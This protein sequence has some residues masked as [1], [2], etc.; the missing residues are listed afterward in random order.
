M[1]K[2]PID[3]NKWNRKEH[4]EF[5]KTFEDPSF[6][7][8]FAVD[9][10]VAYAKAKDYKY[11]FFAMY[12]HACTKALNTVENFRYRIEDDNVFDYSPIHAS[13]TILRPDH[14]FGFSFIDYSE[15]IEKFHDNY[16]AEKDRIFSS[17]SLFPPKNGLDCFHCSALPWINFTG[18]KEPFRA[19]G[20]S[21]PQIAFSKIKKRQKKMIMNISIS[22]NH[23]LVDG[24]HVGQF[25]EKFQYYLNE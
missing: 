10:S 4:F 19:P 2:K 5:F 20:N 17:P 15:D 6:A 11:S 24:Y 22:V 16:L 13:A 25:A 7:V 14:T 9:V 12:L 1:I 21:V 8:C 23:A 18:H 3:I